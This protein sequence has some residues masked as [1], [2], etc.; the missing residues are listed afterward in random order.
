MKV[1][2]LFSGIGGFSLGL[3]RAGME[4]V[5]FCE[6]DKKAQLVLKKHWPDVPI[7]DDVKGLNYGRLEECG[8]VGN[9]ELYGRVASKKP[10]GIKKAGN[11][12][13]KGQKQTIKFTGTSK[14]RNGGRMGE[15]QPQNETSTIDLICGGFPC[16]PF[17]QAGKRR[18]EEDDRHLWP[19]YFRLIQEIRPRWVLCENVVGLIN[20]GLDQVLSDLESEDY[21]SQ[22]LVIPACAVNA[23]HRRDR[24]WV[25]AHASSIGRGK[26]GIDKNNQLQEREF[27]QNKQNNWD[28]IRGKPLCSG[29]SYPRQSDVAYPNNPRDR[30]SRHENF[31][32]REKADQ[33]RGKQPLN[34]FGRHSKNENGGNWG[35]EPDVGRVADGIPNRLDRIR[36]LGNA[37]VP[38]VVE[39]IGRAIMQIEE[40]E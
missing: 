16:Q 7:F 32:D 4:T 31:K 39:Q 30:T 3:E 9:A 14:P 13:K 26:G 27:P 40:N 6:Y 24:V 28:S 12:Y 25:L 29:A 20:M 18:G 1:L 36:Q 37:V 34:Q 5:A 23:P 38:Q 10:R 19:E 2:D 8:L 35:T 15:T 17:S 22:T 21:S 33:R 11:D